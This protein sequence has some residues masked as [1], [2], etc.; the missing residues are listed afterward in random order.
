MPV[1]TISQ[2]KGS[3]SCPWQCLTAYCTTNLQK[4]NELGYKVLPHLPY[5][6]D[7]SPTDYHFFKH[8]DNF[9]QRKCFPKQ[10]E[11]ENAFQP[12]VKSL[13]T[14]FYATGIN[15]HISHWQKRVI[16]MFPILVNEDMF[17]P[18]YNDLS[19]MVW[20][21][22]YVHTNLNKY[23]S[24]FGLWRIHF[25]SPNIFLASVAFVTGFFFF[26]L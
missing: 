1:A 22:N 8:L 2:Q 4:L 7:L 9:L 15:R 14:G 25:F 12:F 19:F 6:S 3:N 20:S 5:W 18:R 16:V 24:H 21:C 13:N 10:Q 23:L 17:E 11:A 26:K